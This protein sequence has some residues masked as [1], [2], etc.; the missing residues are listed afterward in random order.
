[1]APLI[2]YPPLYSSSLKPGWTRL[3]LLKVDSW[4]EDSAGPPLAAQVHLRHL[5]VATALSAR[6]RAGTRL[7]WC[8]TWTWRLHSTSSWR[9]PSPTA[10]TRM[11]EIKTYEEVYTGKTV[12]YLLIDLNTGMIIS[13]VSGCG[14]LPLRS[15]QGQF[16]RGCLEDHPCGARTHAVHRWGK[17]ERKI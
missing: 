6:M 17:E 15:I 4:L 7:W 8:T 13:F 1:M 3:L 12:S 11:T 14:A 2:N 16:I 10:S 5:P 9:T